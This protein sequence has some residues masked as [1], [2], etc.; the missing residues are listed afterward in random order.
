MPSSRYIIQIDL[1]TTANQ[2]LDALAEELTG[3]GVE[4]DR[5]YRPVCINPKLG[6][7]V[8]RGMASPEARHAAERISGV[9]FFSDVPVHGAGKAAGFGPAN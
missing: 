8:M 1:P 6:R 3:T 7:Y 2:N 9:Q 4:L 5:S